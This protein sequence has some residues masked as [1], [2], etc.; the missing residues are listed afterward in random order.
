MD[1]RIG[2]K[3]L[4]PQDERVLRNV[5]DGTFDHPLIPEQTREFLASDAHL[6]VVAQDGEQ[7][8]G[9]ATGVIMLHPDKRPV[10]FVNEVSVHDDYLRR[11]I[12]R[13][14]VTRLMD[15]ARE[16][17]V[18]TF[19]LATEDDNVAARGLYRALGGRETGNIVVYDWGGAMDD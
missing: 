1:D 16:K 12:G 14:L 18:T 7:V 13:R 17:G 19:W 10:L 4:G 5:R 15:L 2:I 9:M 3:A 6:I 11:G 8:I